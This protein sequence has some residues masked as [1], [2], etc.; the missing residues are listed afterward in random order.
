MS[1]TISQHGIEYSFGISNSAAQDI[2]A[3]LGLQLTSINISQE[4]E[5]EAEAQNE[6]GVT[7]GVVLGPT[8]ANFEAEGFIRDKTL[9][10]AASG[11]AF[12]YDGWYFIV[13]AVR[14]QGSNRDFKK[15]SFTGKAHRGIEN[16]N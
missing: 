7:D 10:D 13:R 4:P 2:A 15:G 5:F 14:E 1:A 11:G 9:F 3:T 8:M 12:D 6:T 16:P